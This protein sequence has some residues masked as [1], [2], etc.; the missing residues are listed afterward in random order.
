MTAPL[1]QFSKARDGGDSSILGAQAGVFGANL[2]DGKAAA[3]QVSTAMNLFNKGGVEQGAGG[4][5]ALTFSG[6][7]PLNFEK[8]DNTTFQFT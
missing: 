3:P 6:N 2:Y 4:I 8:A 7:K 1:E 5:T